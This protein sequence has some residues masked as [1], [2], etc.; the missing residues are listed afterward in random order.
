M[1]D[2]KGD[3]YLQI[4][5]LEMMDQKRISQNKGN[6]FQRI[7]LAVHTK[8][9]SLASLIARFGQ[10]DFQTMSVK[11]FATYG[12]DSVQVPLS[13]TVAEYLFITGQ[14]KQGQ[15]HYSFE[16]IKAGNVHAMQ[17]AC[18]N[19]AGEQ[20]VQGI[21]AN[22][23]PPKLRGQ[24]LPPAPLSNR[25]EP[26][27]KVVDYPGPMETLTQHSL[28]KIPYLLNPGT[29]ASDPVVPFFQTGFFLFSKPFCPPA[30]FDSLE[31]R[32]PLTEIDSGRSGNIRSLRKDLE[33]ILRK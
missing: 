4:V 27:C 23:L 22:M 3:V 13:W 18:Q 1:D 21:A 15:V 30:G 31:F 9:S 6:P 14:S 8:L 26:G 33:D 17:G 5:P 2:D 19:M 29:P 24:K 11:L 10:A 28:P 7:R 16:E 25:V 32:R 12:T 20:A